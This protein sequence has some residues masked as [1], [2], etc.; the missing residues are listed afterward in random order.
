MSR[1]VRAFLGITAL[2]GLVVASFLLARAVASSFTLG[3]AAGAR[4]V[5]SAETVQALVVD[6]FT[7]TS[8][9]PLTGQITDYNGGSGSVSNSGPTW[10]GYTGGSAS[11][12]WSN[13]SA[14][15]VTRASGGTTPAAALVS[16]LT[17]KA[18]SGL[19]VRSVTTTT[20]SGL[21]MGSNSTGGTGVVARLY[22]S[23]SNYYLQMYR[24]DSATSLSACG[25]AVNTGGSATAYTFTMVYAPNTPAT[26]ATVSVVKSGGGGTYN[27]TS[28]CD[29]S[30]ANGQYTGMF[31]GR[32]DSTRYD[33]F[34]ITL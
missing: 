12:D 23:G 29:L 27:A 13:N 22:R 32:A 5:S 4:Q 15:Y 7:V 24:L 11:A 8:T 10:N 25:T 3:S 30:T 34:S 31:S 9:V 33:N 21:V 1:S 14:D 16:S 19:I 28:T 20:D 2:T 18:T 26:A 17:R 6:N